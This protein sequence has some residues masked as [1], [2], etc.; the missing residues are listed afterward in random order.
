M[1]YNDLLP[2]FLALT[3]VSFGAFFGAAGNKLVNVNYKTNLKWAFYSLGIISAI[4]GVVFLFLFFKEL[5]Y[6]GY[7]IV[8]LLVV[9][10]ISI[11]HFTHKHLDKKYIYRT[12]ELTPIINEFT[13]D[14]DHNEIK[15]FGGDLSFLGDATSSMNQNLQYTFLRNNGF[16][17]VLILCEEPGNI[18][19]KMR[20]GKLINE[21]QGVEL[22]FYKPEDADLQI[23]GRLKTV[24]GVEKLLIYSKKESGKYQAIETDTANSNGAL[25]SNIW[26]LVWSL[27]KDPTQQEIKEYLKTYKG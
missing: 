3:G 27:A 16:R 23:R 21:L 18:A 8:I 2:F 15:L 13:S 7:L 6:I 19:T 17:K 25:Y 10:G 5:A 14:A 26:N 24:S 4:I 1:T 22:K 11:I 9:S 12:S 20:Y